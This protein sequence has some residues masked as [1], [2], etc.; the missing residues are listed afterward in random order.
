MIK[1]FKSLIISFL[2]F[3]ILVCIA[4]FV[5]DSFIRPFLGDSLVV[6]WL[7]FT[8]KTFLKVSSFWL[9]I[10]V[11]FIAYII[12]FLQYIQILSFLGLEHI[13]ILT[14]VFGST[15]DI[16]DILAYT[17]GWFVILFQIKYFPINTNNK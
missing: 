9:S 6:I 16:N 2:L 7:Y 10:F 14:I 13:R 4:L 8:F 17:L 11:L 3:I 5:H 15:F 12:E 1:D